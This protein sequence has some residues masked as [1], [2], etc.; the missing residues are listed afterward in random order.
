MSPSL[1][2]VF[3]VQ[4]CASHAGPGRRTIVFLKG[5][6]L[7]CSWCTNPHSRELLPLDM[8]D[9]D[10]SERLVP[11]SMLCAVDD[12]LAQCLNDRQH[13]DATGGGVTVSGGEP[14]MQLSFTLDLLDGLRAAGVHTAIET[15]GYAAPT[16][17]AEA[18]DRCD[19]VLM[20][21]KHHNGG[22]HLRWT[23]RPLTLPLQNLQ[24][25]LAS[26]TPVWVRL[27]VIPGV[28]DQLSDAVAFASLF[29]E[30][31]VRHVQLIPF[32]QEGEVLY[33]RLG[34]EYAFEGVAP[35]REPDVEPFR[36]ALIRAGI[37]ATFSAPLN[38]TAA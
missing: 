28:N 8:L 35:L 12:V 9:A 32:Q 25:A 16:R 37:D 22:E 13:F 30:L 31:G 21:V 4:R 19:L 34:W 33:E 1:G 20:D 10:G 5:C 15:T 27:P 38:A 11:D 36:L 26:D 3:S 7:D 2:R 29:N 6:P 24:A 23:G 18:L 17:L 14:L